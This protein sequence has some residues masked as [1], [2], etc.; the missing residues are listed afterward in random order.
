MWNIIIMLRINTDFM[1]IYSYDR[2]DSTL[3]SNGISTSNCQS[4]NEKNDMNVM[5]AVMDINNMFY[6]IPVCDSDSAYSET[7]YPDSAYEESVHNDSEYSDSA[8]SET[9]YPDSA[10]EES[11]HNDS[12]YSDSI[13]SII[14]S[15]ES[16][17]YQTDHDQIVPA[18][19]PLPLSP[20]KIS[21]MKKQWTTQLDSELDSTEEQSNTSETSVSKK[22]NKSWKSIF[23]KFSKKS[24]KVTIS[25]SC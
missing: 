21:E 23:N 8:Y 22:S 14:D 7:I 1:S 24:K 11:V 19:L 10:Y 25:S 20:E 12:E 18:P 6:G 3:P 15:Y 5:N 13:I 2:P 16:I 4:I 9:I 17:E